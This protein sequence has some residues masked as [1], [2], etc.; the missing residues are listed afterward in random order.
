MITE[1][2]LSNKVFD[3]IMKN[4]LHFH[5]FARRFDSNGNEELYGALVPDGY[6]NWILIS[7]SLTKSAL[8]FSIKL[9]PPSCEPQFI[10]LEGDQH[11]LLLRR[12][13]ARIEQ[14]QQQEKEEKLEKSQYAYNL[15]FDYV[16]RVEQNAGH[17]N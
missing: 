10:N 13:F 3:V 16:K 4:A 17:N 9:T 12:I 15:F 7:V 8:Y 6:Q 11:N 14:R 5:H 2:D 1:T